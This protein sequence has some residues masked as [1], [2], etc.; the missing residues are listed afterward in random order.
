MGQILLFNTL[1]V[2]IVSHGWVGA[3]GTGAEAAPAGAGWVSRAT[4]AGERERGAHLG[5]KEC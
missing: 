1:Y 5:M 3:A 4:G 2:M